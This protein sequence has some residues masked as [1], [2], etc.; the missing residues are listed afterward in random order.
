[1]KKIA[2]SLIIPMLHLCVHAMEKN[3]Q[4]IKQFTRLKTSFIQVAL[5][6]QLATNESFVSVETQPIKPERKS[7]A[8]TA[9]KNIEFRNRTFLPNHTDKR[10]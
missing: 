9:I 10:K 6:Y 3:D 1:M 5:M 8:P 4:Q 2:F 7:S